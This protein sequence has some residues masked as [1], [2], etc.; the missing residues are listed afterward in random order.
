[1]RKVCRKCNKKY[2]LNMFYSDKRSSDGKK[3]RC[4]F[5]IKE[6]V[7]EYRNTEKGKEA[8]RKWAKKL[9][10]TPHGKAAIAWRGIVGRLRKPELYPSY[11]HIQLKMTRKEFMDWAVPE[12]SKFMKENPDIKPSI[13]RQDSEGNYEISN[14]RVISHAQNLACC[15]DIENRRLGRK[16]NALLHE[17]VTEKD[18]LRNLQI[19]V[20]DLCLKKGLKERFSPKAI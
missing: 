3:S 20:D 14:I 18:F 5:C 13:D 4:K 16:L 6:D 15:G 9:G 7:D 17:S 2:E 12:I 11:K 1:M 8:R 10:A 19:I